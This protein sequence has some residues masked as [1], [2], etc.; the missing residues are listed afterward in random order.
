MGH[1]GSSSHHEVTPLKLKAVDAEDLMV[2]A[3]LLQD[4]LVPISGMHYEKEKNQFYLVAN[5]FCWEC[6]TQH[7]KE[8]SSFHR[9][10]SGALFDH[11]KNV[12]KL[13]LSDHPD[14]LVNLLTIHNTKDGCVHLLF[15]GGGKI[16]LQIE[17]LS[18]KLKDLDTAYT[19]PAFPA[20]EFDATQAF[21][22]PRANGLHTKIQ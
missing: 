15:S 3:S 12:Q 19:T 21:D 22:K 1:L 17:K 7:K 6:A 18:C 11:V 9:I 4:A 14:T 20:H 5:R 2:I 8:G 13:G 16:K 10:Q